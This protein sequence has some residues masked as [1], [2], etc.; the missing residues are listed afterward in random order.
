M[1]CLLNTVNI[2]FHSPSQPLASLCTACEQGLCRPQLSVITGRGNHSQG[3]VPRIRLAVIDYLT[4]KHYRYLHIHTYTH[5]PTV[6]AHAG[7]AHAVFIVTHLLC[8][9]LI[10]QVHG[11]KPRP[12]VG[13]FEVRSCLGFISV[14]EYDSTAVSLTLKKTFYHLGNNMIVIIIYVECFT[15]QRWLSKWFVCTVCG[16][17]Q[18]IYRCV[19]REI[20]FIH[21]QRHFEP[22]Y[23]EFTFSANSVPNLFK[24]SGYSIAWAFAKTSSVFIFHFEF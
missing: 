5:T 16:V 18:N 3:G 22:F 19:F 12:L 9:R 2:P 7:G 20:F 24:L 23:R 8:Y 21:T 11:A 15:K 1:F 4:N 17:R 14:K 6:G 10:F 13:L